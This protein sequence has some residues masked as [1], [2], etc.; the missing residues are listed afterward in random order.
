LSF[1]EKVTIFRDQILGWQLDIG[2]ACINGGLEVM[3]HSGFAV[4]SIVFSY[5][6]MIAKMQE[7]YR[8][9]RKVRPYFNRGVIDVFPELRCAAP[10]VRNEVLRILYQSAR[11]GLYHGGLT[12]RRVSISADYEKPM[13]YDVHA[14]S[15]RI[16]PH[17]LV[18]HLKSHFRNYIKALTS[19]SEHEGIRVNFERRFDFLQEWDPLD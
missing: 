1:D 3:R 10:V 12:Q 7:G 11:C 13:I 6:E 2:D 16:N 19:S 15:V 4:L 5:F 17:I 14:R 9:T 8:G 18:P